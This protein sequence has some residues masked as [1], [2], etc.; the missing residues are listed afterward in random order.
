[1]DRGG[2]FT[3]IVARAPS[4]EI[5]ARKLLTENPDRKRDA[6][7]HVAR[8]VGLRETETDKGEMAVFKMELK[9]AISAWRRE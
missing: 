1:M 2:T 5:I 8:V 3:D 7:A 9:D 6:I 4:G